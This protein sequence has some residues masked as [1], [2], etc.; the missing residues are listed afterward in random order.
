MVCR[1]WIRVKPDKSEAILFSTSQR[2]KGLS[3]TS[4][5]DAAGSTVALSTSKIKVV[6]LTLDGNLNF[7]D[8]VN[9][10]C[11]PSFFDIRALCHMRSSLSEE[12]ANVVA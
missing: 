2:D 9:N 3:V 6:G 8:R 11:I 7:N 12:M 1:K 4:T 10:V 5:I